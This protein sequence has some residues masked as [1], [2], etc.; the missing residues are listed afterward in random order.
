MLRTE[1]QDFRTGS[2]V[3]LGMNS[4]CGINYAEKLRDSHSK[5]LRDR[6]TERGTGQKQR[7]ILTELG[8]C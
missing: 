7:D 1:R 2:T 8:T 5:K 3:L 4:R 6:L